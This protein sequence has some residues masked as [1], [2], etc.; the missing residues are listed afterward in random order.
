MA[1]NKS[2][3]NAHKVLNVVTTRMS[4]VFQS[5]ESE[6]YFKVETSATFT[7]HCKLN[8]PLQNLASVPRVAMFYKSEGENLQYL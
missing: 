2:L 3:K 4:V 1:F 7:Q 5:M 6:W 8:K